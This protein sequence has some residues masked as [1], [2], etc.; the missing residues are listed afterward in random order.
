MLEENP[1]QPF[2]LSDEC[3]S[4]VS[5]SNRRIIAYLDLG[6]EPTEHVLNEMLECA[7]A[8]QNEMD[9]GLQVVL[10]LPTPSEK[11]NTTLVKVLHQLPHIVLAFDDFQDAPDSLARGMYLE[12]G[13]WPLVLLLDSSNHGRYGSCGYSVGLLELVLKLSKLIG[14]F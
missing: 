2:K 11:N 4:I 10:V 14:N 8:L 12:P 1:L 7:E 13:K 5:Q 6:T 9:S 3:G